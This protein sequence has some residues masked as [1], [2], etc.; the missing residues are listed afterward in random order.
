MKKKIAVTQSDVRRAEY[1]VEIEPFDPEMLD[2]IDETG[3]DNICQ[4]GYGIRGLTSVTHK[5]VVYGR[6]I[7][8]IGQPKG[9]T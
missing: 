5:F 3:C 9:P 7:S 4:Y 8:A 2:F 6:H 1:M